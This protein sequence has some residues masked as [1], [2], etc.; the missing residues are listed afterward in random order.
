MKKLLLLIIVSLALA[1]SAS[2]VRTD[3]SPGILDPNEVV[4]VGNWNVAANWSTGNIP[5]TADEVRFYDYDVPCII[6]SDT[7][8][9][10]FQI[11]MGDNGADDTVHMLTIEGSLTT[12]TTNNWSSVGYNRASTLNVE[13]GG[14]FISGWRCGIG[15]NASNNPTVP[16][17]L[18]VNGGDVTIGGNLQIGYITGAGHI[19]IV[20]VNSGTLESGGWDWR[21]TTGTWSFIDISHG[22]HTVVGDRTGAG[23]SDIPALL[24]SGALTAYG[25]AGTLVYD[26]N[27]TNSGKTTITAIDPM[28]RYPAMEE[29]VLDGALTT[30]WTN[31]APIVGGNVW[32]DVWFGTDP[33]DPCNYTK[34]L[35]ESLNATSVGTSTSPGSYWWQVDTYAYGDPASVL[36]D[37][38]DLNPNSFPL[39]EGDQII[40]YSTDDSPPVVVIDTLPTATWANEPTTLDATVYDD[41]TSAV[42]VVWTSD[43]PNAVFTPPTNTIPAQADYSITGV[44]V[45]TSM[46]CNYH[47]AQITVTASVSDLLN[48]GNSDNVMIDVAENACQATVAVLNYDDNYPGDIVVDCAIGMGDLLSLVAD[49]LTDYVLTVPTA[50][51]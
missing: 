14:S 3:W 8:A 33:D 1:G 11:K 36:Y 30:T 35:T 47:A 21:D 46:T 32:V 18:N 44:P 45:A 37:S 27:V 22:T 48:I 28:D 42:T 34:V 19:G 50:M 20:N 31:L 7:D 25:G 2:A 26:Y 49:W 17:V 40:F 10:C 5:T 13:R 51:P 15:L 39:I 16:S 43:E 12:S 4:E 6:D 41:G 9:D 29:F 23:A 38:N 24:A